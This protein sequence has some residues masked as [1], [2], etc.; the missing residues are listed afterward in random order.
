[1]YETLEGRA[2]RCCS[3]TVAGVQNCESRDSV[4]PTLQP[5]G[6][7]QIGSSHSFKHLDLTLVDHVAAPCGFGMVGVDG[8]G[9][10][11]DLL[12]D[13]ILTR[14]R[15]AVSRQKLQRL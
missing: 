5:A 9:L 8:R 15:R 13:A 14:M 6:A 1:M 2:L 3:L 11:R 4:Q 10:N 7:K 12:L